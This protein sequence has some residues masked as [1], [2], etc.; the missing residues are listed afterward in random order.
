M[1][2]TALRAYEENRSGS[3]EKTLR[4]VIGEVTLGTRELKLGTTLWGEAT[5]VA[6]CLLLLRFE[7]S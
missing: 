3:L 6:C 2:N 1:I 4:R 5:A 7:G